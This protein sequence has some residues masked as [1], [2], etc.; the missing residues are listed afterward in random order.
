M[1]SGSDNEPNTKHQRIKGKFLFLY[2]FLNIIEVLSDD[3]V[4]LELS[5]ISDTCNKSNKPET[6]EIFLKLIRILKT[7]LTIVLIEN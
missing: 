1:N 5:E 7:K 2:F 6:K 3:V 4:D